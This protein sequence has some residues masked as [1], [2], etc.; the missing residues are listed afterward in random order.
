MFKINHLSSVYFCAVFHMQHIFLNIKTEM[1]DNLICFLVPA[2]KSVYHTLLQFSL[3][4]FTH[5]ILLYG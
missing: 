2:P 5:L 4:D 1:T 3:I